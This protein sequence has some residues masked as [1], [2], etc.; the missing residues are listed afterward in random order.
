ME[1]AGHRIEL[2]LVEDDLAQVRLTQEA[3]KAGSIPL[4]LNIAA[5]GFEALDFLNRQGKYEKAPRPDLILLDLNLPKKSGKQVLSEI[6]ADPCLRN[7]PVV[8]ITSSQAPQDILHAYGLNANCY[9][10]KPL[11]F[12][13]FVSLVHSLEDFWFTKA[14]LPSCPA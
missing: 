2:L 1:N 10:T 11:D 14:T 6:K 7:I 5:D 4:N 8:I 12:D 13:E 9:I 3:L